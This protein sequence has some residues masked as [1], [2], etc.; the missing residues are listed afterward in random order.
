MGAQR[1]KWYLKP[2]LQAG[3]DELGKERVK[4]CCRQRAQCVH[5][6]PEVLVML[7]E[8]QPG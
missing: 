1:K 3:G 7:R 5:V 6:A 8:V 4:A 2:E